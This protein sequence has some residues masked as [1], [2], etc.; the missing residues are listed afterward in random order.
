MGTK[1]HPRITTNIRACSQ[2]KI[3]WISSRH[4]SHNHLSEPT[5]AGEQWNHKSLG[6]AGVWGEEVLLCPLIYSWKFGDGILAKNFISYNLARVSCWLSQRSTHDYV[7]STK[8]AAFSSQDCPLALNHSST[9]GTRLSQLSPEQAQHGWM[10][11]N[12]FTDCTGCTT[13]NL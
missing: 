1:I 3:S 13:G 6:S 4:C 10:L 2:D 7:F 11:Y 12:N 9:S 5:A 8:P